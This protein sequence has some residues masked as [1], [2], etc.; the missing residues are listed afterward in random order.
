MHSRHENTPETARRLDAG[1]D[2]AQQDHDDFCAGTRAGVV[3]RVAAARAGSVQPGPFG[4][5]DLSCR[6]DRGLPAGEPAPGYMGS[7]AGR[8]S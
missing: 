7:G 5:K 8:I 2:G 4:T 6:T 1:S 3:G